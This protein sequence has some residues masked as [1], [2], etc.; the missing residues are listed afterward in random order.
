MRLLKSLSIIFLFVLIH[1]GLQAQN[2]TA[3][4]TGKVLDANGK[5]ID[6]ANISIKNSAFGTV[7]NS[8]GIYQLK[9]PAGKTVTVVYSIIGYQTVEKTIKANDR[10]K[11][12][13]SISMK[14]TDQEIDE[15]K[16]T[17]LRRNKTNMNRIDTKYIAQIADVGTGGV[18]ALIKTLPGVS[19]NNELSSQYSVR[20]GNFD[21]NLVYINDV[22]VYRPMLTKS[23]QQEGMSMINSDMVSSIDF[24]A[25]GFDAKYGDKMSSVLDIKYRKPTEFAGSASAS[26]LGATVHV[27]DA[28]KNG[29]FTHISGLRYKTNRYLLGTLDA[30]GEYNPNFIDFQT[31]LT[32]R[33]N[34]SFDISFLGNLGRNQYNFIPQTR[35]TSFGTIN[36]VYKS[37]IYFEGQEADKYLTSTGALVGNYHPGANLNLKFIAS[38]FR[39]K[40]AETY[41]ILGQYYI[42]EFGGDTNDNNDS[43]LITGVDTFINHARNY[44]NL[45][46]YAFEHKGAYNSEHHLLNWGA[47]LQQ[48]KIND[49]MNEWV[50][51]DSTGYSIPYHGNKL[52]L[53]SSTNMKYN[54]NPTRIT[55]FIQ[56]TYQIPINRGALYLTAGL[57]SQYW[58]YSGEFLLSPRGTLRYYPAWN[59]NF[60]FHLSGGIYDQPAFYK[61]LK[62][63]NGVIYPNTKAQRSTQFVLGTDYIFKAWDRPFKFSSEM[64]YKYFSNLTPYQIDNVRI[65]YLPDQQATGYATGIDMKVNGEFVSGVESWASLAV[66][67]TEEDVLN[68]GHGYIPRPT[69]QR[70]SF[71]IFFQDYLPGNPTWKMNLTAFYGSRLPTG[72]PNSKRYQDVFRIPPYRRIDLGFS[73]VLIAPDHKQ[74]RNKTFDHIKDMWLSLEVFNLLDISNTISYLWVSNNSGD[75]FAVPNYLT[76]RK[77]NLKLTVKF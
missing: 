35:E 40:E 36:Q 24:S 21:E 34:N 52:E 77:L 38:A 70:F 72:P 73:K 68:D 18:E 71:S 12:E 58:S 42:K 8:N 9:I 56:D 4:L 50:L 44:L 41:D 55:A 47:K 61:E 51:R 65:R 60:V 39:S 45:D 26:F 64:Y 5:P 1:T 19:T 66:M 20:G 69:D 54:M 28:S 43:T 15:V 17:Q 53:Y 22:E 23:G 46:V 11:V 2:S 49:K 31:Y 48:E 59:S 74:F 16:V 57:R 62:D 33:F 29:K 10:Q 3:I 27:E 76:R 7:S 13:L 6:L 32:Y 67:K 37:T 14:Q 63:K 25:G 30:K 75:M